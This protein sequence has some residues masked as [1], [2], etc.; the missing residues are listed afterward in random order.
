M[1]GWIK[2]LGSRVKSIAKGATKL[3]LVGVGAISDGAQTIFALNEFWKLFNNNS[4]ILKGLTSLSGFGGA[5]KMIQSCFLE[6]QYV[7]EGVNNLIQTSKNLVTD[8]K[9]SLKNFFH[10]RHFFPW[11]L[12]MAINL[13]GAATAALGTTVGFLTVLPVELFALIL[14]VASVDALQTMFTEGAF[15]RELL[16]KVFRNTTP[17]CAARCPEPEDKEAYFTQSTKSKLIW[18]FT[19]IVPGLLGGAIEAGVASLIWIN[20]LQYFNIERTLVWDAARYYSMATRG[21]QNLALDGVCMSDFF[22]KLSDNS[23]ASKPRCIS[24]ARKAFVIMVGVLSVLFSGAVGYVGIQPIVSSFLADASLVTVSCLSAILRATQVIVVETNNLYQ[25]LSE[26][27][28]EES[29]ALLTKQITYE[30]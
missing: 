9:Q 12:G 27:K 26:P 21:L 15:L 18:F 20:F 17:E 30:V 3:F 14:I 25:Q 11:L 10:P 2:G 13:P 1:A 16:M 19:F 28:E 24:K 22:A 8:P 7:G 29:E 6:Y 4:V 5:V 23:E